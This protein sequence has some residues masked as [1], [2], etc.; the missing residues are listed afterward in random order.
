MHF[1]ISHADNYLDLYRAGKYSEALE[2]LEK[3]PEAQL[4]SADYY[5]N[6]GVIN[7]AM[8]RDGLAVSF[9][10][11][12]K[13]M[14]SKNPS[15]DAPLLESQSALAKQIGA[16]RLDPASHPWENL[17]DLLPLNEFLIA[18]LILF[19]LSCLEFFVLKKIK[20]FSQVGMIVFLTLFIVFIAWSEWMD[21]HPVAMVTEDS[22]IRSGPSD[23]VFD[24]G[25]VDT[26]M[27]LR[28]IDLKG[29]SAWARV[30]WSS[31]GDE[32]YVM[33]KSLLILGVESNKP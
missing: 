12:A 2:A 21:H 9:L 24:R 4:K 16:H 27:R 3:A 7:H 8:S 17:G 23:S 20:E 33:K 6:K 29:D 11:K 14:D 25:S 10:E 28:V 5:Y 19:G 26:G 32:G 22:V 31:A 30:R 15:I 1:S 18:S 13:S